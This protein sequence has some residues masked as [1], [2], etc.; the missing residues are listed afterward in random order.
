MIRDDN[1]QPSSQSR[2]R[3]VR[4]TAAAS[5]AA[6]A[7]IQPPRIGPLEPSRA[8]D[9]Y[10]KF[11]AERQDVFFR[12]F[13]GVEP[14]WTADPILQEY[15]FTNTYRAAD[16]VSQYL[17]RNVIY[18]DDLPSDPLEVVFRILLFKMF[19]RIE[20]WELLEE[21][22][23]CLTYSDYS[24]KRYDQ[25]LTQASSRGAKIY[26]AAYIMPSGGSLGHS[27]KHRNHL[28]LIERM[29][30]DELPLRLADA[31]SM[32]KAFDLLR[33]Y[34][35]IGDFLAYQYVTD[36]NYSTVTDFSEMEFVVA[37]PGA[38]DGI[39]KCFKN[40]AGMPEAEII[41]FMADR[42]EIEFERLGV[43]FQTLWGRRLQLIDCQNLFCEVGK[44]SRVHH[45]EIGGVS[46]RTR[47]KQ[48]FRPNSSPLSYWF[49]PKWGI[50]EAAAMKRPV[51]P[52]K[53]P[54]TSPFSAK[55]QVM[56]FKTYQKRAATT[57]RNPSD[58]PAD[59]KSMTI[60]LLGI[61]GEAGEV[62]TEYK[63][64]L[65]DGDSNL[66]FKERFA[67]E[68]GDLLWYLANVATKFKLDLSKIAEQNLAK[69]E[70][71]FGPG[72]GGVVF[73]ADHP[74]KERLPRRFQVDFTTVHDEKDKPRMKAY[75][76]GKQ[77]GN[78][79][80]D[81]S[82][83]LDGYRFHDV[84]H[85]AFVA[86]L[87]W[88]PITRSLLERKRR[89]NQDVDEVE[90]GGR[91][92]AIEE[93]ISALIFTYAKDY[94]WLQ[95]KASVGSELLRTIKSMTAHLEVARCSTGDWENA[96]VQ[97]F[98]VWREI[99]KRGGGTIVADLDKR[100]LTIKEG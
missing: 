69:C 92:K 5:D 45:P 86:V 13:Q 10:W 44:Y 80:T 53:S 70:Q 37:G 84:F 62:V 4:A 94:G 11:A 50:N 33:A 82:Y 51:D 67:E 19:N 7:R 2:I 31:K 29:I 54:S 56:D 71:R 98:A 55:E 75:Y 78:D 21:S 74:A 3:T 95:G 59:I 9:T 26:S 28:V 39:R 85:L 40:V 89:S 14:P 36:L 58:D 15:K 35:T 66:L 90:D 60:K 97:G 99:K 63:K 12:R 81:N 47:I 72:L 24:F 100:T 76:K 57:D 25:I 34:P 46:G 1:G 30:A 49:P 22:L 91:A 93:G 64:Y 8:Y 77:F 73:D 20:T 43:T 38:V 48:K 79:L 6:N 88:S 87:G 83:E 41:K 17:I 23:G 96:I 32:Q 16:R 65:R 52:F 27:R 61:A 42:Q 18:R 68:L